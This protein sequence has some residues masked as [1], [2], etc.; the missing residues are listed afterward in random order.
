MKTTPWSPQFANAVNQKSFWK[1]ALSLK[2]NHRRPNENFRLWAK[3]IG[4]DDFSSLDLTTIKRNYRAAQ[5][6]LREVEKRAAHLQEQHLQSMLTDAELSGDKETVQKR[7]RVLIRAHE[8]K[9]QFQRLKLIL[10]PSES[11]G[12]SHV[13]VPK[14]FSAKDYPYNSKEVQEWEPIHDP[15]KVR[16]L[17]QHRNIQNFGQAQGTPFTIPPLN[18]IDWQAS[19]VKAEELLEG[20]IPAPFLTADKY[21]MEILEHI[22]QRETL[23][24]IDTYLT[25][26]QVSKGFR[27]W[28]EST[29]TSPSGFHLGLR[30]ITSYPSNDSNIK[31]ARS[32][33]LK[34]QTHIINIPIQKGFSPTRWQTIVNAM[35]KKYRDIHTYTNYE[36][37]TYSRP[38][39]TWH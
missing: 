31:I 21:T 7:L 30:R 13:L 3:T 39:T 4:V 14:D 25:P 23:P 17:I 35:I 33:L 5:K 38:I 32:A 26:D 28:R 37:S 15:E 20:S 27:K 22:A 10:K 18:E 6:E 36:S 24:T 16:D 1:I 34:A 29:L 8:R 9:T 11:G 2:S 12:M 19:S